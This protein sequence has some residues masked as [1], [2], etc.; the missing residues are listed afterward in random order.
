MAMTKV[1]KASPSGINNNQ[2]L[3]S[4]PSLSEYGSK[5]QPCS[6]CCWEI[7]TRFS[8]PMTNK[9]GTNDKPKEIS[10]EIIWLVDRTLPKNGY[11]EF[12]DHPAST[13]P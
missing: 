2:R 3:R 12:D 9:T 10:Y 6:D 1:T 5:F 11:F 13:M 8:S 7:V 4:N